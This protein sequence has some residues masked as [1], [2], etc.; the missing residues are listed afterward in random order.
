[1]KLFFNLKSIQL[2]GK[3]RRQ[4][5]GCGILKA[6]KYDV[7]KLAESFEIIPERLE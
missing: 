2:T 7:R 1:M 5:N 4:W 6:L 3:V